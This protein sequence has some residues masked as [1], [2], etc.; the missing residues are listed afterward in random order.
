MKSIVWSDEKNE[1]LKARQDRDICFEDIADKIRT[2]HVLDILKHPNP[3]YSHQR[4]F[5]VSVR[6][7][8]YA[9]P[10]VEDE[11][12]IFLKT[13]YPSRDLQRIYRERAHDEA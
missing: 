10:F 9:V 6:G 5:V 7:Y 4:I 3:K 13:A 2:G 8:V 1:L 11:D 12:R